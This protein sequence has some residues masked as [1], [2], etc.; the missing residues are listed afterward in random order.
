VTFTAFVAPYSSAVRGFPS[1]TVQFA[2]DGS[3]AGKPV[4]VDATGQATWETSRLKVG[5]SQ[6]T[7]SYV[8]GAGSEFLP[9]TSPEMIH[10][11]KRC[12]CDTEH[13]H[14]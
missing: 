8:P 7:A 6:V 9:S 1:G 10:E 4:K 12:F 2:V 14:K 5:T 11:V 3:N 13:E